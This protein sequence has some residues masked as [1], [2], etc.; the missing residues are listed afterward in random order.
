MLTTFIWI[1]ASFVIAAAISGR[2]AVSAILTACML[3]V[4]AVLLAIAYISFIVAPVPENSTAP[5]II[6]WALV[7]TIC[8][9]VPGSV[10]GWSWRKWLSQRREHLRP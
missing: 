6:P 10:A 4:A 7:L 2:T 9:A 5:I 8:G 1:A 3:P